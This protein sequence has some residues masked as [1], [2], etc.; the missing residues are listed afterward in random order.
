MW[1]E[2]KYTWTQ[3]EYTCTET[4]YTWTEPKYTWTNFKDSQTRH[5]PD[6]TWLPGTEGTKVTAPGARQ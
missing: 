3:T 1:T 5:H 6:T 4:K 2:P